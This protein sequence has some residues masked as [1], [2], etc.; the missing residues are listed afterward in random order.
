MPLAVGVVRL[1][2][3]EEDVPQVR[4]A[5]I[6]HDLKAAEL[7]DGAHVAASSLLVAST[8]VLYHIM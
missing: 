2:G 8:L 6:A 1:V 3:V 7:R 4:A 5:P